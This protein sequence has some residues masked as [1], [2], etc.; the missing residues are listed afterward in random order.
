M[1]LLS[2][3]H[4]ADDIAQLVSGAARARRLALNITQKE[5][6]NRSGV[7]LATLKRFENGETASFA[8]VLA[9]AEALGALDG[10]QNVFPL[11]EAT[12]LSDLDHA[13]AGRQ[14]ARGTS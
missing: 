11:P 10:F 9:V 3:L 12:R 7:A 8:T 13:G 2:G 14:R 6:S 4:T 5:L 1:S